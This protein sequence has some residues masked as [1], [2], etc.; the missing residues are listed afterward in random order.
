MNKD[1]ADRLRKAILD[2]A[3]Q[4]L[5]VA[6]IKGCSETTRQRRVII[7]QLLFSVSEIISNVEWPDE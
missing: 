6:E 2:E 1:T 4:N 5:N 7:A 3:H